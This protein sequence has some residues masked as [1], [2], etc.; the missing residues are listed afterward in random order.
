MKKY[1]I[2]TQ[3]NYDWKK[4]TKFE[5]TEG[6]SMT[7]PDESYT[8]KELVQRHSQGLPAQVGL[9]GEYD[10]DPT[11]EDHDKRELINLD[12]AE[13][14]EIIEQQKLL[15]EELKK[16]MEL[17]K[18]NKKKAASTGESENTEPTTKPI[19]E[20]SSNIKEEKENYREATHA[21]DERNE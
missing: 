8:I 5:E 1:R 3:Y 19:D 7:V 21:Q 12:L 9:N 20:N 6:P 13:K 2:R 16:S 10:E 15:Q 11:H 14:Q 17:K 4:D 18:A